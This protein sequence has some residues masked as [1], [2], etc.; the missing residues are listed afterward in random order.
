[1]KK[2][3]AIFLDRDGVLT[4]E[5]FVITPPQE[6]VIFP[7]ATDC[8]EKIHEMGY[9]TVVVTNQ[10][11]IARGMFSEEE[12]IESNDY[13]ISEVGVDAVYY[14][15]HYLNGSVKQYAIKCNCRKPKTGLIERA[16]KDF[17]IDLSRS[18]MVG[19]RVS[20]IELGQNVGIKTI[21]LKSGYGKIQID[22]EIRPDYI[23][24]D[25][26]ECTAWITKK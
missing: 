11:G 12:L 13:F 9:L 24:S 8:I 19:D 5:R 7:Y 22:G 15:P 21:L 2:R 17:P 20:D 3:P 1:V 4:E 25:L 18:Y 6:M 23:F 26:K 16:C 14:C 10:S